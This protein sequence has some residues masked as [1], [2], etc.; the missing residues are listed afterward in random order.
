MPN[1]QTSQTGA[2]ATINVGATAYDEKRRKEQERFDKAVENASFLNK[3]EKRDWKLLGLVLHSNQF[4][5]IENIIRKENLRRLK[6]QQQLEKI[7][8]IKS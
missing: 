2:I 5:Q 4:L 6:M 8:P 3:K 7:K 1:T